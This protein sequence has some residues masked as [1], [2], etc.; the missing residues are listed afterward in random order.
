MNR[1]IDKRIRDLEDAWTSQ[2]GL[3]GIVTCNG[4]GTVTLSDDRVIPID[5]IHLYFPPGQHIIIWDLPIPD[6]I[7]PDHADKES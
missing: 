2:S 5:D 7:K 1:S 3:S 6:P 4:D